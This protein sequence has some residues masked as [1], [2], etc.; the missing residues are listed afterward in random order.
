M[1]QVLLISYHFP[2]SME[3][4][5]LRIANFSRSLP[6]FGWSPVV[7]TVKDKYIER[8]DPGRM[9]GLGN[10]RVVKA[11]R[12]ISL[13]QIYLA[14]KKALSSG[15]ES[16]GG[17]SDDRGISSVHTISPGGETLRM[18]CRRVMLAFMSLPDGERSWIIP[19]ACKAIAEIRKGK[20]DCIVTSAPPYSVHL[21]G[22]AVK[23]VTGVKWIADYRDQ[24]T[25]KSRKSVYH[26][27][28]LSLA[29]ENKLEEQVVRNADTVLANTKNIRDAYRERYDSEKTEKFVYLP[30]MIDSAVYDPYLG[31]GKYPDFTISHAGSLYFGRTPEPLFAAIRWLIQERRIGNDIRVKLVGNCTHVNGIPMGAVID[32]Y[33]LASQVDISPM[34]PHAEALEII[35]KSH[36]ALLLAPDQPLQIPAKVYEYMGLGTRILAIAKEG[37][38]RDLLGETGCGKAFDPDDT[39]GIGEFLME[40]MSGGD[41]NKKDGNRRIQE[42]FGLPA[43]AG[44]LSTE[45][46]KLCGRSG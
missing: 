29:I 4:G 12:A 38:T 10:T 8:I 17:G 45:L 35:R 9:D 5:G 2:P 25:V 41:G 28:T 24:W 20:I 46:D 26:T 37:A 36:L 22:L 44:Q 30:N 3:V 6:A 32:R 18:K 14:M 19:A 40:T 31:M 11:G 21:V 13:S 27:C 7:L 39:T 42:L 23:I 33:G 43:V 34:V 16:S 15:K 1:K